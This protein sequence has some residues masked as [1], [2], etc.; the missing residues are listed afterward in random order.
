[1][2]Y[3]NVAVR[4][5]VRRGPYWRRA[6]ASGRRSRPAANGNCGASANL[7][8]AGSRLWRGSRSQA[9]IA[10]LSRARRRS[11]ARLCALCGLCV[12]VDRPL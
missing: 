8:S 7:D 10:G 9:R 12:P 6:R 11:P 5:R 2:R 1:M 4:A 3:A